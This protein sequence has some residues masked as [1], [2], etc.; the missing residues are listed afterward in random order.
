MTDH[1]KHL[2]E[3]LYL[4]DVL[5]TGLNFL[6]V[7]YAD[8]FSIKIDGSPSIFFGTD[9]KGFFIAT[10]GILGKSKARYHD[11]NQIRSTIT[12]KEL[13]EK[14]CSCLE[15]LKPLYSDHKK[16]FQADLVSWCENE[17]STY[18]P[19]VL[20]YKLKCKQPVSL[21]I[22]T[23]Y[24]D[25]NFIE[26]E[27]KEECYNS[28]VN[29]NN[30]V[31]VNQDFKLKM[32]S[33]YNN[34]QHSIIDDFMDM[35]LESHSQIQYLSTNKLPLE[36]Y[37]NNCIRTD[38]IPSVDSFSKWFDEKHQNIF[39]SFKKNN[40]EYSE[41]LEKSKKIYNETWF[42]NY[43]NIYNITIEYKN[44]LIFFLDEYVSSMSFENNHVANFEVLNGS[45]EG[46]VFNFAD[47]KVKMVNRSK[48]SK[49]NF[50]RHYNGVT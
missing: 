29:F 2:E 23:I 30:N 20:Q 8:N 13:A 3:P 24:S 34:W 45:H 48:F 46:Y 33:L 28:V 27:Y 19:N 1:I 31:I 7:T 5:S 9:D 6:N 44:L 35:P 25:L 16:V 49:M 14:L 43:L 18:Q 41:F 40:I 50:L 17:H 39:Q 42:E 21:T 32:V 12:D 47:K 36:R 4:G 11:I 22:H 10:K 26:E 38:I 37:F 15:T